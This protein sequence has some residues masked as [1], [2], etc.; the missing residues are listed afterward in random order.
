MCLAGCD[1][2]TPVITKQPISISANQGDPIEFEVAAT[3]G[4]DLSYQW[5]VDGTPIENATLPIY[6]TQAAFKHNGA[7]FTVVVSN[8][9]A[10][11]TSESA[12]L[13]VIPGSPDT[14]TFHNDTARTGQNLHET[15]LNLE[16]V[17]PAT[18]GKIGFLPVDGKVD[19]QPLYLSQ[20]AI[21]G[22]GFRNVVY[23]VTEHDSVYAFDADSGGLLWQLS[24]L[25]LDETPSDW[26]SCGNLMP[27]KGITATPVIDRHRGPNGVMYLVSMSKD[28][29]GKFSQRLH[30][31]DVATGSELFGAPI[32]IRATFPGNG[33][34]SL[35]GNLIFD[36]AQ[37]LER[38]ALL[39]LNSVVY[40]TWSSHCDIAPYNGWIIGYDADT[41]AQVKVLNL[42]PNGSQGAIWM[43][44]SGPAADPEGNIFI[45][46]A[47]GTFDT[48][49]DERGHPSHGNY[50]NSFVKITTTNDFSVADYFTMLN[51]DN[52][53]E[54]DTDL[55]SGGAVVLPDLTDADGKVRHLAV[56]GG[57]DRGIYLVDRENMG[58]FN[59]SSN[60]IY[61]QINELGGAIFSTPAYFNQ[62]IY[63]GALHDSIKRFPFVAGRLAETPASQTAIAFGYPGVTP[64]ISGDGGTD[65]ILWA[66]ENGSTAAL[67]AYAAEDLARELYNSNQASGGR[68]QFGAGNKYIAPTVADGRVFVGTQNGVAVFGLL[69]K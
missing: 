29:T 51:V 5:Q 53:N 1:L 12:T 19:A 38:A 47:N 20:V 35:N 4:V 10:S 28:S 59:P 52:E 36:P 67:H 60:D 43:S 55:G 24:A 14:L 65:A 11:V 58:K 16:N 30:A 18:F 3:G 64:T 68:D 23:V 39:L 50:G 25:N 33:P 69:P 9:S 8:H 57:K 31:I 45:L 21:P 40:T 15:I 34:N 13:S 61:Q 49:L 62:A 44:G 56:G 26:R 46:D 27:E 6:A 63:Y 66:A 54:H 2:A 41:L 48:T 7:K 42:T 22:I 37:Y 17:D 32:D